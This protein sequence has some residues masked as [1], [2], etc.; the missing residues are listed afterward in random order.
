MGISS[1]LL[2]KLVHVANLFRSATHLQKE[3][4]WRLLAKPGTD[5]DGDNEEES[6]GEDCHSS[7]CADTGL[8][9]FKEKVIE[10]PKAGGF[11]DKRPSKLCNESY[12]NYF[13]CLM[14]LESIFMSKQSP[15]NVDNVAFSAA[16]S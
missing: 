1:P 9:L 7:S 5:D 6:D 2:A 12:S 16:Y 8:G 4:A 3:F 14:K 11:E 13:P 10:A 15:W